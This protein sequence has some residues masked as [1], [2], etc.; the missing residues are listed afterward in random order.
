VSSDS[1]SPP[2]GIRGAFNFRDL[3]GL[4]TRRGLIQHGR[5]MRCEALPALGRSEELRGLGL[6]TA[7]DLREPVERRL[8]RVDLAIEGVQVHELPVLAGRVDTKDLPGL[9]EVYREIIDRCGDTI[10]EAVLALCAPQALP[11]LV[12]CAA[13]KDR[14]G[15]VCGLVLSAIGV[16]EADVARDYA[17]SGA[18]VKGAFQAQLQARAEQAGVTTQSLAVKLNAPPELLL[19]ALEYVDG[20]HGGARM[21][22]NQHGVME[23]DLEALESALVD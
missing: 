19:G 11:A 15:L 14:T 20:V 3:G 22:L 1:E 2:P 10:A 4:R 8:D 18:N 5:L 7:I 6:H 9:V 13:G 12:F 23:R 21:Y 16:D 17:I